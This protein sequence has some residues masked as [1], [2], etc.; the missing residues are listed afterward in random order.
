MVSRRVK[1][2]FLFDFSVHNSASAYRLDRTWITCVKE[3]MGAGV[4]SALVCSRIDLRSHPYYSD[5]MHLLFDDRAVNI[6]RQWMSLL[7][8]IQKLNLGLEMR[9]SVVA[10]RSTNQPT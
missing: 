6:L 7:P 4:P 3:Q 10:A 5:R 2:A 1:H 8:A 9:S